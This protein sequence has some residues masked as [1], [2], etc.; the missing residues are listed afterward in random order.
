M[1]T[2]SFLQ[3]LITYLKEEHHCHT[4]ILYGSYSTGDYT[5]ESD[6][7]VVGFADSFREKNDTSILFG[8]QLDAWIYP[9]KKHRQAEEFLQLHLGEVLLD[10]RNIAIRLLK[11][12]E[13]LVHRGPGQLPEN[14]KRFLIAW[15]WKMEKRA[16]K[17][18]VEGNYR[19]N[20][21]LVDSLEIY[22]ELKGDWYFG[23]KKSFAWLEKHDKKGYALFQ[24]AF[25]KEVSIKDIV[26]LITYL[27][28]LAFP[29]IDKE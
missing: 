15:L 13:R 19:R 23:P 17:N 1:N 3:Q 26:E 16:R 22:F 4:I 10:E 5:S 25:K 18:D 20:W 2:N 8:K 28:T 12:I 14:E 21:L 9:T 27:E 29:Q 24:Q 7:D 6:V 11:D